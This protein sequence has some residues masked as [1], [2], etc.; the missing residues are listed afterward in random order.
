MDDADFG[1]EPDNENN[2]LPKQFKIK[3]KLSP[4]KFDLVFNKIEGII[5]DPSSSRKIIVKNEESIAEIPTRN[6]VSY[7]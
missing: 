1:I 3:A 7:F 5:N 6:L 4:Y 2:E